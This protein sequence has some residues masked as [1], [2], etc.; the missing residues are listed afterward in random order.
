MKGTITMAWKKTPNSKPTITLT[1]DEDTIKK[2][3]D[4]QFENRIKSRS[5]AILELLEAGMIAKEQQENDNEDEN[6]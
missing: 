1:I 2:I 4:Y 5:R 3:E 6:E